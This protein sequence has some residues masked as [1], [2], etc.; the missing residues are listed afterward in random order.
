MSRLSQAPHI[1][2]Q[3]KVSPGYAVSNPPPF[4]CKYITVFNQ[5]LPKMTSYIKL[6][7]GSEVIRLR[8]KYKSL[9]IYGH[10][11]CRIKVSQC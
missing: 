7:N 1:R 5:P 3:L 8:R 11:S 6:W 10:Q 4:P 2:K 9:K